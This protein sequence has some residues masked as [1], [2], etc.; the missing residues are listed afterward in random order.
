M[1][2]GEFKVRTISAINLVHVVD[3]VSSQ[4]KKDGGDSELH[5]SLLG[6][7]SDTAQL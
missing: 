5:A 6:K 3:T 1:L 4:S 2:S 7:P